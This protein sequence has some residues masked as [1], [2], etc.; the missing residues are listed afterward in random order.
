MRLNEIQRYNVLPTNS[1]VLEKYRSLYEGI[2]RANA[3]LRVLSQTDDGTIGERN[4]IEAEAKFL[5]AH[6]YFELKRNFNNTPYVDEHWDEITPVANDQDLWPFI[7]SDLNFAFAHLP[8]TQQAIGRANKWAAGAYLAKTHLYQEDYLMAKPL[9]DM[10]ISQGVNTQ[11]QSY[12]LLTSY[13]DNFRSIHDNEKESVFAIQA[14]AGTGSVLNANPTLSLNFPFSSDAPG[15]CCGFFQPSFDLVNSYRT[16]EKGLPMLDGSY[17]DPLNT[18]ESDM[19]LESEGAFS[20]DQGPLDPRL[21]HSVGRRGIPY[22]DWGIHPGKDWIRDQAYGG[23]YSPK[24]FSYYRAGI[25]IEND[26]SG[27]NPGHTAVNYD[28]IRFADVI[29]MAA[30][31]ETEL[32]N[33]D[34]ALAYVNQIRARAQVSVLPDADARYH[35]GLYNRFIDQEAARTAVRFERKLELAGEGHRF[36]DLVRWG[37][38]DQVLNQYLQHEDQFLTDPFAGASFT[39]GKSEYLP[40]PQEEIDLQGVEV[41]KQNPGY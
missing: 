14:A 19:G 1:A 8:E 13:A 35:V 17:N 34:Q 41:L 21:D 10:V 32:G 39:S 5:R 37:V 18:I 20:T 22:L 33:L 23:P 16:T 9:F 24:K 7:E 4:R 31:A 40:I 38:A 29:L 11:G 2:S 26:I 25:G 15:T 6:F 12:E 27:W 30:E 28:I 3:T 36:Y